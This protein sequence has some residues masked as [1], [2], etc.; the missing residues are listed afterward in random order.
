[1]TVKKT[2]TKKAARKKTPVTYETLKNWRCRS[3]FPA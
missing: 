3:A 2:A 1:M